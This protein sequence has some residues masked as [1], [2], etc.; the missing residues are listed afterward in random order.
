MIRTLKASAMT[1]TALATLAAAPAIAEDAA[2]T[3]A[4]KD[5]LGG[6]IKEY[7]MENPNI[8]GEAMQA[9]R[10]REEAAA[11]E[12][13]VAKISENMAYLTRADAPSIGNSD[14]DVTVVEFFDYNCGYCKRAVPDIQALIKDDTNVRVV[15][16]EMPILG[17]TSR[18]AAQW[19]L[20]ANKQG[21]Y[22]DYHVALMEHRGP[23]EEKQLAELAEKIGLD[24]D[25]IK[26]DI[27]SGTIDG[28]LNK[29]T[30]VGREIGV[31]GTPAFIVGDKFVTADKV[32]TSGSSSFT[33]HFIAVGVDSIPISIVRKRMNTRFLIITVGAPARLGFVP[34][35]IGI[36]VEKC[37]DA[38]ICSA[39][40]VVVDCITELCGIRR[41]CA[42]GVITVC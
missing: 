14:A 3:D 41:D 42:G 25:Q 18:T 2:F 32:D 35:A 29:V 15:F 37:S 16:K 24:V 39:I 11:Q 8:I 9:Q 23:K 10:V 21:K 40:A 34:I 36:G 4:Q 19:A 30:E 22:F 38:L 5:A 6:I 20:A 33:V 28:E 1:F 31:T 27:E 13:A 26:K 17:P 12:R 7:I